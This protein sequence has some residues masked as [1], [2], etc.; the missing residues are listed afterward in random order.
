M[1]KLPDFLNPINSYARSVQQK[2]LFISNDEREFEIFL[3]R[4]KRAKRL[5]LRQ[6]N[7][8]NN[9]KLTL[10]NRVSLKQAKAFCR[11]HIEWI[12][13]KSAVETSVTNFEHGAVIPLRG[14]DYK[15][16]FSDKLR[17][18]I[19]QTKNEIHVCG[20]QE[21]APR[22]LQTWLKARAKSDIQT[23]L[24]KYQ[25]ML[26]VKHS[27]LTIRDTKSRWGSCSSSKA[28]SFS[29]RLIMAPNNI[30]DYVVAHELAHILEMNHSAK[31]WA[32][33]DR[34]CPHMVDSQKWL[35]ING[36]QLHQI[37]IN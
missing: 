35:K 28:L 17:G 16:V 27:K 36:G 32:H 29:W 33:V 15:L 31:F 2:S 23:A 5:I 26:Q 7:I 24:N 9:F 4:N 13:E 18:V 25:P 19:V 10:P 3:T 14:K 8:S 21:Y 20:G 22:R 6:D 1:I 12:A 34:V 11:Q 30:L 37:R